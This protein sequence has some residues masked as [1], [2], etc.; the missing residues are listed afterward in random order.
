MATKF[1]PELN[2]LRMFLAKY[3]CGYTSSLS[4]P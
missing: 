4:S 3:L 2:I 1:T